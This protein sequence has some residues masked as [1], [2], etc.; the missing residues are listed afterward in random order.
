VGAVSATLELE[1]GPVE[2]I[3][4]HEGTPELVVAASRFVMAL[5]DGTRKE[6]PA[7]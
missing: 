6:K 4:R 5:R 7:K 3:V 2:D 1:A